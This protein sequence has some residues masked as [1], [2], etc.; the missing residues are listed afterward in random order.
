MLI[1]MDYFSVGTKKNLFEEFLSFITPS[2]IS[3]SN[4]KEDL[5]QWQNLKTAA[6]PEKSHLSRGKKDF[7][8]SHL[9]H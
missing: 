5:R 1:F 2:I 8:K 3:S 9:S 6:L 7:L 4:K